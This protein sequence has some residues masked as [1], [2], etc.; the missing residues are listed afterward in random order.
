MLNIIIG[1][2][3]ILLGL[4]GITRNWY[5]FID[6]MVAIVPLALIFF[7]IAG[8]LPRPL[9]P[10]NVFGKALLREYFVWPMS[11]SEG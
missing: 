10:Q 8:T 6:M 3:V 4:W 7:G 5:M 9:Q 1:I 11:N 2:I